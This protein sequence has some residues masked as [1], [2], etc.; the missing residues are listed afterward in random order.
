M[1][2]EEGVKIVITAEDRF[3]ETMKKIDASSKIFGETTK[4][5]QRNL[6]ALE[7]EMV[8]LVANGLDPADK[9]IKEMKAN[10]DK[11]SQSISGADGPL[12]VANQKWMSL[13]LVVQDLPYGFRGIQN[14]LPALVGSFAAAGGAI[15]F[16]FSALIAITTAYE[17]EIKALFITTTEAEKQQQ[18]YN[19]VVKESGTAY[20][21]AQSQVLSL[22]QKVKLAKDGYIDK[23]SVVNEYNETIGKTIGKQKDLEGVNEALINQGPAY[24]EYI[25]KLSFA[26]ASAKLVA[27]QSEKMIKISMQNATEFVDGWDAFFKAKWNPSGI[28]Q[29]LAGGTIELQ[30]SAEKNRQIQLGEAG[31]TAVGY[32]KIMN[33]AFKSAG[34]AAKKAGVVPD[35]VKPTTTKSVKNTYLLESLKAQQQAQKDDIYQ[36]RV[37]GALIINEEE[38]L[39]VARAKLDGTYLQNKKNIHARYQADR[40]TNDN[41]FE[42][43]LNKILDANAKIRTAQ[44]KK[45][46]EIQVANR[47]MIADGILAINKQFAEDNLRNAILFAK[48]QTNIIE[49]ELAVQD[50]LNRNS[51]TE[52]IEYTKQ[53]LAKLAVLAAY[54]FDPKV[55][56][57]YLDSF[58]KV[59]AKLKGMGTTWEATSLKIKGLIE[60]VMSDSISKFAENI[61]KSFNGE[62]VDIFGGI[63]EVIATGLQNIGK[64]LIAY[65]TAMDAFKLAFT[66]PFAAIAAGV[67]LV[68]SGV[69]LQGSIKKMN[70]GGAKTKKFANGGIISGPTMGLMGE[71]P[72]ARTNPEVVAPLDKLKD[73]IG[74]GG[75]GTFMLRGQDLLLSVNRAQK[76]SN[77]KGQNISLA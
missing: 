4:N 34:E 33:A 41:L 47:K 13:S 18:L 25:N 48:N 23:Q 11:L 35:V 42:A 76:A 10:Y 17:K 58:D 30:K 74:G 24:V 38:R 54:T 22:T 77:L 43:N 56:A 39:A 14:N 15:Y 62:D 75:G 26:M 50:K 36:F 1:A 46:L 73:M 37:Y 44:E 71:Y 28:V 27:E 7:K 70:D 19:N 32:E 59:N 31:K 57:V 29:S 20:I 40:E 63:T 67:V 52:R 60:G 45:E 65:G 64:A 53:A 72:G 8:R 2:N 51:L 69:A 49:T 21:D 5:T 66:N 61:G 9:K 3:T 12:K 68:A 6:E 55:L 16:V